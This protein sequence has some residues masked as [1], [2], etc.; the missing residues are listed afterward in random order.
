LRGN[1]SHPDYTSAAIYNPLNWNANAPI[2]AWDRSPQVETQLL[3][4]FKGRPVWIVNAPS[5]TQ[6][7]YQVVA[8]PLSGKDLILAGNSSEKSTP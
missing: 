3:D 1:E 6:V 8:G 4:A 5:I 7:G 2:Y